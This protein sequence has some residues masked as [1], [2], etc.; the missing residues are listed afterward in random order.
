MAT[1]VSMPTEGPVGN[2]VKDNRLGH[3]AKKQLGCKDRII[4]WS[5]R[6]RFETARKLVS[7]FRGQRL[8]DYG[9]G[10]G[11]FLAQVEDL[12]PEAVGA[13]IAGEQVEDC[14]ARLCGRGGRL[15]F[16]TNQEL[17]GPNH[18][19][20]Y[21][22]VTCMEVLEHCTEPTVGE[23]LGDLQRLCAPGGRVVISVPV[24]TGPAVLLKYA[25]RTV[26]GWRGLSDY[27][28][29]EKFTVTELLRSTF[30]TRRTQLPRPT[31]YSGGQDHPY[32]YHSHKGFNWRSLAVRIEKAF[33]V[34]RVCFSPLG[35]LGGC[36]SS[37]VWFV[38]RPRPA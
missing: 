13:D 4:S 3:Y 24:E 14:K 17:A 21:R 16:L 8:L 18:Q 32:A 29:Y 33:A 34:E 28:Y 20:A 5:H 23:V 1:G 6:T 12:F 31:Y 11:T 10:D 30:A 7:P 35:W 15:S 25:V 26:A 38:C 22:V 9:C 19:G 27:R 2:L 37:Q 36:L